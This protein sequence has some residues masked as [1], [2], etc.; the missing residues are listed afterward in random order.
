M[1][2]QEEAYRAEHA[3]Q[4]STEEEKAAGA[5]RQG[6]ATLEYTWRNN[7]LSGCKPRLVDNLFRASEFVQ[8]RA[9]HLVSRQKCRCPDGN[10]RWFDTVR[11]DEY[12]SDHLKTCL[13][14]A[15]VHFPFPN[16]L[17]ISRPPP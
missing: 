9:M 17:S 10:F 7:I 16:P 14:Q 4:N 15:E 1:L 3:W 5:A 11:S 6:R 2:Y 8:D 13:A 12:R